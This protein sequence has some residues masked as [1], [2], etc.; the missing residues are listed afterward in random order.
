M[1]KV[2]RE[3]SGEGKRFQEERIIV[4]IIAEGQQFTR[5]CFSRISD[6]WKIQGLYR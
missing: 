2:N 5:A 6:L 1:Q 4:Q 3:V